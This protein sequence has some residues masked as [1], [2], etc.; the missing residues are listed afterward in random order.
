[1]KH[2]SFVLIVALLSLFTFAFTSCTTDE[3][4]DTENYTNT[5]LDDIATETRT[6]NKGCFELIYPVTLVF[7]DG[8]T[9]AVASHDEMKA[10][11]KAWK[12][13][14]PTVKDRPKLQLPFSV[15]TEAGTI[16]SV[17][18]EAELAALKATCKE[19]GPKGGG[20]QGDGHHGKP[21]FTIVFPITVTTSTGNV[22]VASHADL[23]KLAKEIKGKDKPS[24]VFPINVKLKDGTTKSV[25]SAADLLALKKACRG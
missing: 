2:R 9:K 7:A 1:M 17:G 6:C 21:C 12:I 22:T 16:V 15:T 10:A 14:N 18:T 11:I 19:D 3:L 13:A 24:F 25:A 4:T 8:S 5:A 20:G 23:H